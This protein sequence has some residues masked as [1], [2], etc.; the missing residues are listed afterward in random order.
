M[1]LLYFYASSGK[2]GVV[3]SEIIGKSSRQ[4]DPHTFSKAAESEDPAFVCGG[5]GSPFRPLLVPSEYCRVNVTLHW[6]RDW[7]RSAWGA[8]THRA[9]WGWC[10]TRVAPQ[11]SATARGVADVCSRQQTLFPFNLAFSLGLKLILF[12][13]LAIKPP[14]WC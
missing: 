13:Y 10:Q 7:F 6:V 11:R 5:E 3:V 4:L 2:T 14:K 1:L 9:R 8:I 12:K